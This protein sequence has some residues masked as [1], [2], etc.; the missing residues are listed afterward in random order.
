MCTAISYRSGDH[1]FGRNLDLEYSYNETVVVTPRNF[2]L[3]FRH[4]APL[5]HH[6]ALIGTAYMQGDY[7]LYYEATNE[8]GLSMAGLNFPGNADYKPFAP[9]FDN[10]A[11]FEFI[12]WVLGQCESVEQ[13]K[14]LLSRINILAEDFSP[15]LPRSP[16][17]WMISDGD[18][19]IAVES[20]KEGLKIHDNP[21]GVLTNNPPFEIQMW[22]LNNYMSLSPA[23]PVCTFGSDISLNCYSRGMGALGLPGDM[24]SVSRFVRAAFIRA[25]SPNFDTEEKAVSQFFHMLSS[26]S[27]TKGSVLVDGKEDYTIYSC[28]CNT[29]RGIY[30]Y[31]TYDNSRITAVDMH[32]EDLDGTELA[33]YSLAAE[34]QILLQNNK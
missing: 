7:P 34:P 26:V 17:H 29:D 4:T 2:A 20:V 5:A 31:T 30:Y 15:E 3:N 33:V 22:N 32:R 1:Y 27:M 14:V 10:V 28:C 13:A 21:A 9:G 18:V 25:N 23:D 6:F 24:S 8:K 19:S 11:P 16:L 12:P